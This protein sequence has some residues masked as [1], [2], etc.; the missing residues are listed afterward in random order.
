MQKEFCDI[1]DEEI[2]SN[3]DKFLRDYTKWAIGKL[4]RRFMSDDASVCD[5]CYNRLV[6]VLKKEKELIA[7]E[8]KSKKT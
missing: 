8:V 7:S 2:V 1:C 5:E 4:L 3:K 6:K